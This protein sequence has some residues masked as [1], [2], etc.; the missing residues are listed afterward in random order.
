MVRKTTRN[1]KEFIIVP[2]VQENKYEVSQWFTLYYEVN[3]TRQLIGSIAG[4]I[5]DNQFAEKLQYWRGKLMVKKMQWKEYCS[6][7]NNTEVKRM[8]D[9]ERWSRKQAKIYKQFINTAQTLR[10]ELFHEEAIARLCKDY[11]EA[12]KIIRKRYNQT[13][14]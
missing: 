12:C 9:Y 13:T 2:K 10:A 7:I 5:N 14:T 11:Q 4:N 6:P 8:N 3:G 1:M